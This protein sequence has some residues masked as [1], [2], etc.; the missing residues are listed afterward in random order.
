[1]EIKQ[2]AHTV[3]KLKN[4]RV[5]VGYCKRDKSILVQFV[6]LWPKIPEGP[7]CKQVNVGERITVGML[8]L[9]VEAAKALVDCI[10]CE[11]EIHG[12]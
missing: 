7:V 3:V 2:I 11:L 6:S 4:R 5:K 10:N 12:L 8:K 9:S 1:M